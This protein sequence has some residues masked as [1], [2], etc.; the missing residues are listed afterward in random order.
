[1]N[2]RELVADI[3][4]RTGHSESE[5][6]DV[7][8]TLIA[9]VMGSVARGEKVVLSGFG[10]FHRRT[11]A[12]RVARNIWADEPMP[13]PAANVPSFR[14]GKTFKESVARRRTRGTSRARSR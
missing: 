12:K 5:V 11:R 1:V 3:S 4:A 6:A 14:P 9:R 7:V 10:T 8:D 13:I 2:K